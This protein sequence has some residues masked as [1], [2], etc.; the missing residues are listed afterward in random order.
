MTKPRLINRGCA[1]FRAGRLNDAVATF[2]QAAEIRGVPHGG[3]AWWNL[4]VALRERGDFEDAL[5]ALRQERQCDSQHGF[6]LHNL[7]LALLAGEVGD[8]QTTATALY[9]TCRFSK[10]P[11]VSLRCHAIKACRD[12]SDWERVIALL[13]NFIDNKDLPEVIAGVTRPRE[14]PEE[15]RTLADMEANLRRFSFRKDRRAAVDFFSRVENLRLQ[16]A[17]EETVSAAKKENAIYALIFHGFALIRYEQ[18]FEA[19]ECYARALELLDR[20]H[21]EIGSHSYAEICLHLAKE[22]V[23]FHPMT[24]P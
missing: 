17:A 5:D 7:N 16:A 14:T 10:S 8:Q 15:C 24:L 19:A 11:S 6:V 13:G 21:E 12:V 4:A 2:E 9:D 18:P 3:Y 23:K 22:E 1:L 20:Y